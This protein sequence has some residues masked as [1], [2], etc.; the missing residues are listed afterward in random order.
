MAMTI[1]PTMLGIF[2]AVLLFDVVAKGLGKPVASFFRAG[3]YLPQ[4]ITVV[5]SAY[6]WKWLYQPNWGAFNWLL[7][8][9]K[10]DWVQDTSINFYTI[11]MVDVWM[12][13]PFVMLLSLAGLSAIPEYLYEAAEVDRASWRHKFVHITLPMVFPTLMVAIIFRTIEAFKM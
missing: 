6:T 11:V 2:L 12:W 13:T 1:I 3:F 8:L 7:G 9:Y 4:V 5:V 10:V